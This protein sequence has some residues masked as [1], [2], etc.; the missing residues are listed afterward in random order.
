MENIVGKVVE[1]KYLTRLICFILAMYLAAFAYNLILV[2]NNIVV[3][4]LMGA[5]ILVKNIFGISTTLFIDI[6]DIILVTLGFIFLGFRKAFN[7]MLGC[8]VFPI[9]L[10]GSTALTYGINI[11]IESM[12]LSL[13]LA[14]LVYGFALGIIDRCGFS[15]FG[16]DIAVDIISKKRTAP[17]FKVS[18]AINL[19]I[20]IIAMI[21]LSP[22]NILYSIYFITL[23]HIVSN[24]IVYGT[25]T[26]KMIY[27]ISDKDEEIEEYLN[28]LEKVNAT[29]MKVKDGLFMQKKQMLLCVVHNANY[30]R[31]KNNVLRID[32]DAFLVTSKCF[33]L[34]SVNNYS[35]LPF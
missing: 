7:K 28:K 6:A 25:S 12:A 2:P 8:I 31:V 30:T 23:T 26:M 4:G 24:T 29:H 16:L 20:V 18:L 33:E 10:T 17:S 27:I 19:T 15:V 3:G 35:I 11:N 14:A 5:S 21:V 1:R 13:T 34:E 9:V 22:V 32:K